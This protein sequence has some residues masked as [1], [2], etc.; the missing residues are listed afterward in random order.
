MPRL[1]AKS[2]QRELEQGRIW[3]VYWLHGPERMKSRELLRR[4]RKAVGASEGLLGLGEENFDGAEVDPSALLDAAQSPSLGGGIRLIVVRE[5][6]FMKGG[7]ALEPLLFPSPSQSQALAREEL[8][9]VCVF[10]SQDLDAR[11]KF[12]KM[13]VER[14]AVV[15]CEAVLESEREDWIQYLARR[16]G[17][18]LKP[19]AV[20]RIAALDPW[21]LDIADQE[22]EKILLA[23]SEGEDVILAQDGGPGGGADA[24]LDALFGRNLKESLRRIEG[25]AEQP[26]EA[27]PL[28]GLVAWNTRHLALLLANPRTKLNPYVERKLRAW[29]ANWKLE[30]VLELEAELLAVDFGLKQTPLAPLGLWGELV[31]RFCS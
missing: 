31:M 27:L 18:S 26:D 9:S 20:P 17:L 16:R 7:D 8:T 5:A 6:H 2:I 25:F 3:P 14:A 1:E 10:L 24:F 15:S 23:G 4:I 22:L 28:L 12:S 19:E 21:S 13:L 30:E 11:R 29:S